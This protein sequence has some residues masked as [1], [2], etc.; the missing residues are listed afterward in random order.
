MV[1]PSDGDG[2]ARE[3]CVGDLSEVPGPLLER[4]GNDDNARQDDATSAEV[5]STR[6]LVCVGLRCVIEFIVGG[7]IGG[8]E[9]KE[10]PLRQRW[11]N[12]AVVCFRPPLREARRSGYPHD[13]TVSTPRE[14]HL[15]A[16]TQDSMAMAYRTRC[17]G[18]RV[19]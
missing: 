4:R 10:H 9:R 3:R 18:L 19:M 2:R 12:G 11:G 7:G 13:G 15:A 17:S 5:T 8:R 6:Q 16:Y 1:T 14:L